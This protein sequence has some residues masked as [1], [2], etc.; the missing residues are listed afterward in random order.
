MYEI[1]VAM[2]EEGLI[3]VE[4]KLPWN[5][6]GEMKLFKAITN[7]TAVFMG[8]K[9]FESIGK[10]LEGRIN[11]IITRRDISTINEEIRELVAEEKPDWDKIIELSD[12]IKTMLLERDKGL[13]KITMEKFETYKKV[14]NSDGKR[15]LVIGGKEIYEKLIPEANIFHISTIK[16]KFKTGTEKDVFLDIDLS[17]K[18]LIVERDYGDFIYRKYLNN[19]EKKND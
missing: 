16:G 5:V 7:D 6:Q 12:E 10:K 18:K 2:D 14:L 11:C 13:N 9:T 1:I 8:R 17:N 15:V 19:K 4:N 3:G